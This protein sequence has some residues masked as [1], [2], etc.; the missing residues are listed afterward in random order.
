MFG[1]AWLK[2]FVEMLSYWGRPLPSLSRDSTSKRV[3]LIGRA[4]MPQGHRPCAIITKRNRFKR[5]ERIPRDPLMKAID[6]VSRRQG[7][8]GGGRPRI[9][10][11]ALVPSE[12]PGMDQHPAPVL[13]LMAV[14]A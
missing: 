9:V 6:D 8:F 13:L 12:I 11:E 10:T 4:V 3:I 14:P 5:R 7:R 1:A 2:V